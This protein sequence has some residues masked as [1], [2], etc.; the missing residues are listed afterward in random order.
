MSGVVIPSN[1]TCGTIP[2][3]SE[4]PN[5]SFIW[6]FNGLQIFGFFAVAGLTLTAFFSSRI[7]RGT[8]WYNFMI[9]WILWCISYF[10]LIGQQTGSC[11]AFGFCLFQAALVY[12]GPPA[13]ACATLAILLQEEHHFCGAAGAADV[14]QQ[15][16][17][18]PPVTYV[19]RIS[20]VLVA[21]FC[22]TMLIYEVRTFN[23]LYKNWFALRQLQ[24]N[25]QNNVPVTM[26]VR[27][28]IFSFMPILALGL[29]VLAVL[30]TKGSLKENVLANLITA[31]LSGAAALIFGTQRDLL[32]AMIFCRRCKYKSAP[33]KTYADKG[34]S[35]RVSVTVEDNDIV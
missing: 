23:I 34:V 13:N 8:T 4:S 22:V 20:A 9:G 10:A 16:V 12:A 35:V 3:D 14:P 5:L 21:I 18:A 27:I 19:T 33:K 6:I 29:S 26:I 11:P 24:T 32:R 31:S 28:S 17:A 30:P 7:K 1:G 15:L 25:M 2:G